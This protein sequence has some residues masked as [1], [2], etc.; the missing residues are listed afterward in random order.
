MG[1]PLQKDDLREVAEFS[2]VMDGNLFDL[3]CQE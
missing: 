1:I 3:L 2:V